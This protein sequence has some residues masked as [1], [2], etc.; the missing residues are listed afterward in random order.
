MATTMQSFTLTRRNLLNFPN[1]QL[2]PKCICLLSVTDA[3]SKFF[4]TVYCTY[5]WH[6]GEMQLN[7]YTSLISEEDCQLNYDVR[8]SYDGRKSLRY[9]NKF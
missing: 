9:G 8:H 4:G 6:S 1:I 7:A 5:L 3:R 2:F